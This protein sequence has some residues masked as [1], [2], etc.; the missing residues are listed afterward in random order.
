MADLRNAREMLLIAYDM[1]YIDDI[2]FAM[3]YDLNKSKNPE[4]PL[5][6]LRTI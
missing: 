3:F 6:E 1:G 2:E 4:I 5:L